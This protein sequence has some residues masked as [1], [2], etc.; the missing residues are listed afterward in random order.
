MVISCRKIRDIK[1]GSFKK[2]A[3]EENG[4]PLLCRR[5]YKYRKQH[6]DWLNHG[7]AW[8]WECEKI[9][10]QKLLQ[11]TWKI[12]TIKSI[13]SQLKEKC[14]KTVKSA[15]FS[16]DT[17]HCQSSNRNQTLCDML[18]FQLY[19]FCHFS[20]LSPLYDCPEVK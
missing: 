9:L 16:D 12:C 20:H 6:G 17:D 5:K 8:K 15:E 10:G 4:K 1:P 14:S 19:V 18:I 2:E 11:R 7:N 3:E 13:T